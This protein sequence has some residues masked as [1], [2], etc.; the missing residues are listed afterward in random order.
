[1]SE[2]KTVSD[3]KL[4]PGG[5]DFWDDVQRDSDERLANPL[6]FALEALE[7]LFRYES[8]KERGFARWQRKMEQGIWWADDAIQCLE[9][10]LAA[11]PATMR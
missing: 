1:M 10:V 2:D 11:P 6:P 8:D 3:G 9:K 4:D 5:D 7:A